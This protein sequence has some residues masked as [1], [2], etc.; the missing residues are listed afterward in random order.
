[1]GNGCKMKTQDVIKKAQEVHQAV[2]KHM[3]SVMFVPPA[4]PATKL[5]VGVVT[6]NGEM[7]ACCS[8]NQGE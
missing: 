7:K 3:K 8:M 4:S 5:T 6:L 2:Q 1:M